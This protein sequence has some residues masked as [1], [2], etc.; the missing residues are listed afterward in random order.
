MISSIDLNQ[1]LPNFTHRAND[2]IVI[3]SKLRSI[4]I[5]LK[6]THHSSTPTLRYHL[7]AESVIYDLAPRTSF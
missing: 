2:Q 3:L 7:P 1:L 6:Y 5:G 4:S